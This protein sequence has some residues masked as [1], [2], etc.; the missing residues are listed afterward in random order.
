MTRNKGVHRLRTGACLAY[1][2]RNSSVLNVTEFGVIHNCA[3]Q[4]GLPVHILQFWAVKWWNRMLFAKPYRSTVLARKS[5]IPSEG[6][7]SNSIYVSHHYYI[8]SKF[9]PSLAHADSSGQVLRPPAQTA[10]GKLRQPSGSGSD[11]SFSI[12]MRLCVLIK[13]SN[14]DNVLPGLVT[15]SE[16]KYSQV[17]IVHVLRACSVNSCLSV[18]SHAAPGEG[19]RDRCLRLTGERISTR[20]Q[21]TAPYVYVYIYLTCNNK[22]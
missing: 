6:Y 17:N 9:A 3:V 18:Y 8:I 16:N 14:A 4:G 13:F 22:S 2:T 20:G 5:L 21:L 15:H 12:R 7:L 19:R 11:S 1:R 10:N